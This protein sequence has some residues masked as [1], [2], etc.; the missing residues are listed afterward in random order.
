MLSENS[1]LLLGQLLPARVFVLFQLAIE[2][3]ST[4]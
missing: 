1:P 3:R 2:L 4:R